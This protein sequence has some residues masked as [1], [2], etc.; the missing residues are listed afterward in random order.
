MLLTE[1]FGEISLMNTHNNMFLWRE[2]S[3]SKL[4][5]NA[6]FQG[7]LS[8]LQPYSH[9]LTQLPLII[10]LPCETYNRVSPGKL[11]PPLSLSSVHR[12]IA[13]SE[14]QTCTNNALSGYPFIHL[15]EEEQRGT[16]FML[17]K[18]SDGP[19]GI[20]TRDP[21]IPCPGSYH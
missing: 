3:E 2:V 4:K 10:W 14:Y 9:P 12:D 1:L 5:L 19:G 7:L 16:N 20:R 18:K 15:G 8:A 11:F 21:S 13:L 17:R 6:N